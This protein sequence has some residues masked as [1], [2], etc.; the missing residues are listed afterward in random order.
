MRAYIHIYARIWGH[1]YIYARICGHIHIY[2]LSWDILPAE[3]GIIFLIFSFEIIYHV[4]DYQIENMEKPLGGVG[5]WYIY[6]IYGVSSGYI[7]RYSRLDLGY[8]SSSAK[9]FPRA[10]PCPREF[11]SLGRKITSVS[12]LYRCI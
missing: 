12:G 2:C 7:Q 11:F 3:E 4:A 1:I 8:F 10:G 6:Y 5:K 9:K